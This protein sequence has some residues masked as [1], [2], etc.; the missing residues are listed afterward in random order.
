MTEFE[1]RVGVSRAVTLYTM[2]KFERRVHI[3]AKIKNLEK[4]RVD[5]N[6]TVVYF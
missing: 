5:F 1:E 4:C 6:V 2:T 3:E